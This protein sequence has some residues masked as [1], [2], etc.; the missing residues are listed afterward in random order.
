MLYPLYEA[1]NNRGVYQAIA[2][3]AHRADCARR[4]YE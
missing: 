1:A 4:W 2:R 3:T